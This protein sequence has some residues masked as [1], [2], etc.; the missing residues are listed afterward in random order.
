MANVTA[1]CELMQNAF[2]AGPLSLQGQTF[3]VEDADGEHMI[4]SI[5]E[6]AKLCLVVKGIDG[7]NEMINLSISLALGDS[8]KITALAVLQ[9][10]QCLVHL[11]FAVR[12]PD[13]YDDLYVMK[14]MRAERRI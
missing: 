10:R 9:S 5:D 6:R 13:G 2:P 3:A 4:F 11:A 1:S 12:R 8:S 14:P 7:H